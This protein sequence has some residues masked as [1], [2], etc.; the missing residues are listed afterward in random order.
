MIS[1][2]GPVFRI[3]CRK[4]SIGRR[5]PESNR[6]GPYNDL[7]LTEGLTGDRPSTYGPTA[8]PESPT[9]QD[10]FPPDSEINHYCEEIHHEK[11]NKRDCSSSISTGNRWPRCIRH[12]SG[13]RHRDGKVLRRGE[14]KQQRLS[15][16]NKLLC[17]HGE[18]RSPNGCL[19][20][21]TKRH[22]QQDRRRKPGGQLDRGQQMRPAPGSLIGPRNWRAV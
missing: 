19:H 1:T 18:R 3:G 15:D 5:R 9:W 16:G 22:L 8:A 20:R 10:H 2:A 13:G 12:G 7:R 21:R 11:F 14:S 6:G 17:R 4:P